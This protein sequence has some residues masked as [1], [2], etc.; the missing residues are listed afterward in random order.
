MLEISNNLQKVLY[1]LKHLFTDISLR[2]NIIAAMILIS[3][4]IS[5]YFSK[6]LYNIGLF[7]L[8]GS[9]TN[10]LAVHMLFEKIPLIYGSGVIELRFQ[11]FKLGIK[12]LV[13]SQ[14]FDKECSN[15]FLTKINELVVSN[16]KS[17]I[18]FELLY[19]Q[20]VGA[21]IT[22][23]AGSIVAMIG[24]EAVLEPLREPIIN[25][26]KDFI[27]ELA[28]SKL[29]F[30]KN[31]IESFSLEAEKVIARKIDKL[32]S[33]MVK[34]IVQDIIKKHLGWLVVWGGVFGGIIGL[35]ATII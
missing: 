32:T 34:E 7:A 27:Q 33:T 23:P 22:S 3:G 12:N 6:A 9:I 35:I 8:S 24:G 19:K 30:K 21:I 11:D 14:F 10:W 18:D 26:I 17:S 28:N 2:T 16:L 25:K 1:S 31:D 13:I 4:Y 15:K 20:L 5:P 29:N